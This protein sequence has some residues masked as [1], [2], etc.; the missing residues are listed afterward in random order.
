MRGTITDMY[1]SLFVFMIMS[2]YKLGKDYEKNDFR[3][4]TEKSE[5][6]KI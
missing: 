2:V 3:R 5:E 1:L 4:G 6:E